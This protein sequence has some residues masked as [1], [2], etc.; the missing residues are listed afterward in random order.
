M[1]GLHGQR[2]AV[3]GHDREAFKL[4]LAKRGIDDDRADNGRTRPP[5]LEIL[6]WCLWAG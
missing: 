3:L 1:G 4:F 5:L 2:D 6:A